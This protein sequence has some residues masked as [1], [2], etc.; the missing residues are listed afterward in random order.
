[1]S[2][3]DL[4]E[5]FKGLMQK[6]RSIRIA[7]S[8]PEE[9]PDPEDVLASNLSP[10]ADSTPCH[11]DFMPWLKERVA[12]AEIAESEFMGVHPVMTYHKGRKDEAAYILAQ[13]KRWIETNR[14]EQ[15]SVLE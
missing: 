14:T 7:P 13:F 9:E 6:A 1:M 8:P 12:R 2:M 3:S 15:R 5:Q 11:E 10:W 4:R